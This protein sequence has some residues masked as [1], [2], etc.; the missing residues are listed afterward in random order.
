M[1]AKDELALDA[2]TAAMFEMVKIERVKAFSDAVAAFRNVV[3]RGDLSKVV[4]KPSAGPPDPDPTVPSAYRIP[5]PGSADA[6]Y[7]P[8]QYFASSPTVVSQP[9]LLHRVISRTKDSQDRITGRL[10]LFAEMRGNDLSLPLAGGVRSLE[11]TAYLQVLLPP[12][13]PVL[14]NLTANVRIQIDGHFLLGHLPVNTLGWAATALNVYVRLTNGIERANYYWG[15]GE[16]LPNVHRRVKEDLTAS[17][18]IPA[19]KRFS[20]LEVSAHVVAQSGVNS[21][22]PATSS[23]L[24]GADEAGIYVPSV[25]VPAPYRRPR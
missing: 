9:G 23:F 1:D 16:G 17:V 12:S 6:V 8:S 25:T 11:A 10:E 15:T 18:A 4:R 3:N 21:S 13:N 20:L 22:L 19:S 24:W 14:G 7:V 5:P 2:T